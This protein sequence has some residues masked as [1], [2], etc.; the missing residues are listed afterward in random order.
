VTDNSIAISAATAYQS[1]A[2]I[3]HHTAHLTTLIE[4]SDMSPEA[5]G[6]LVLMRDEHRAARAEL[7]DAIT[8][9][10]ANR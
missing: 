4:T 6:T 3:D 7:D 5:A 9:W 1:L 10:E 2:G 8:A